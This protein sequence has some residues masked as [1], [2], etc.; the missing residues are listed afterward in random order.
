[1]SESQVKCIDTS[2]M[3]TYP[4]YKDSG[5]EWI[6]KIPKEWEVKK[7]K[8][9]TKKVI[10]GTHFTPTYV[11]EGIPFL[12]VTDIHNKEIDLESVKMIP[13]KEHVELIKR[14]RP[15]RGDLLLSKNGT[16]GVPCVVTWDWKFSIFVSL[17]LIKFEQEMN[18][19]YSKYLFLSD[20]IDEQISMGGKKNTITNLHLDKIKEFLFIVPLLPEQQAISNFL[21]HETSRIDALVGKKQHIIELL[22]EKRS[23]LISHTVTKGLNT[24]VPMKDSGIEWVGE[25][26]DGW[27]V[28]RLKHLLLDGKEGLK[29]GPFGSSLKLDIMKEDGY[30]VYGQENVIN[31]NFSRGK[32]FIDDSKFNELQVYEIH[33][34]DIVITMMGTT[35]KSCV[36]PSNL[37]KG[38]M[39]SHLM[40]IRTKEDV[41]PDYISLLINKSDYINHQVKINSNGAIMDGLNSSIV[42]SLLVLCPPMEEQNEI[43]NYLISNNRRFDHPLEKIKQSIEYLKEYRTA[44]ISD[45]VTGKIDV[46]GTACE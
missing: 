6:G 27:E 40:R 19:N 41:N 36:V 17:C 28:V 2:G 45:A 34:D 1:M 18:V 26:P 23:A 25:I 43:M 31:E 29:I 44:L 39:D 16:I 35:G 42:K 37:E 4:E 7:L 15:E 11:D 33:E 30:K 12:R 9:L 14:C 13:K 22:E 32:R 38:I 46:R 8:H 5:V 10:D 24:N 21:D 20:Q 3:K